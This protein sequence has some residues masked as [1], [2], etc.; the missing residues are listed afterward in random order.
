MAHQGTI[1]NDPATAPA[2]THPR[3]RQS[4]IASGYRDDWIVVG[5]YCCFSLFLYTALRPSGK[6]HRVADGSVRHNDPDLLIR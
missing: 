5:F 6:S 3:N 2:K 1:V 4:I